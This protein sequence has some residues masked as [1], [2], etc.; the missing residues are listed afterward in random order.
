LLLPGERLVPALDAVGVGSKQEPAVSDMRGSDSMSG[1]SSPPT[2]IPEA[3]KFPDNP[4]QTTSPDRGH[5][6]EKYERGLD[7]LGQPH[8]FKEKPRALAVQTAASSCKRDVLAGEATV[9]DVDPSAPSA[10]AECLD[11][12]PDGCPGQLSIG[13]AREKDGLWVTL[14]FAVQGGTD[15]LGKS[16]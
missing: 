9:D 16:E 11:V 12:I 14:D 5:V 1:K 8:D 3:G 15:P 2:V 7:F 13:H 4:F 6:F 10:A